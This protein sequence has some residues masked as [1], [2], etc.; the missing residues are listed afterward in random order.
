M[1]RPKRIELSR[2]SPQRPQRCAS[3]NSATAA[4]TFLKLTVF[5]YSRL[6]FKLQPDFL[7]FLSKGELDES[8]FSSYIKK[9][10]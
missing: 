4:R 9:E 1:V 2:I 7:S 10:I 3:T 8:L 5:F 6:G